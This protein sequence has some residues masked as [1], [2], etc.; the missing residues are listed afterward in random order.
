MLGKARLVT[1]CE[2]SNVLKMFQVGEEEGEIQVYQDNLAC[3]ESVTTSSYK[4]S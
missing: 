4:R 3:T 1:V 2:K